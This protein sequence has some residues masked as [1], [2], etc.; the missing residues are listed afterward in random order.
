MHDVAHIVHRTRTMSC[1]DENCPTRMPKCFE[2]IVDATNKSLPVQY[3]KLHEEPKS[4]PHRSPG[5]SDVS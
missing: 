3:E 1:M 5:A 2:K 4:S